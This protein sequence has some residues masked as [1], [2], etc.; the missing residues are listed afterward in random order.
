MYMYYNWC[1]PDRFKRKGVKCTT[2]YILYAFEYNI[3]SIIPNRS[4]HKINK[5]DIHHHKYHANNFYKSPVVD[6]IAHTQVT[7]SLGKLNQ[8]CRLTSAYEFKY[9]LIYFSQLSLHGKKYMYLRKQ[10]PS[11]SLPSWW[12]R[13]P[14]WPALTSTERHQIHKMCHAVSYK[15]NVHI[16]T[17]S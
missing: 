15:Y 4:A 6:T 2:L 14:P 16:V 7:V 12:D 9:S 10:W 5:N 13:S 8:S 1:S 17:C 3:C 11:M